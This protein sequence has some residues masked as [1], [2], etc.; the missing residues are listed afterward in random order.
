MGQVKLVLEPTRRLRSA[1]IVSTS[2]GD[3]SQIALQCLPVESGDPA[4]W[5]ILPAGE[6]LVPTLSELVAPAEAPPENSPARLLLQDES[7]APFSLSEDFLMQRGPGRRAPTAILLIV[8]D[9]HAIRGGSGSELQAAAQ[10]V[11]DVQR[12]RLRAAAVA[13]GRVEVRPLPAWRGLA[14]FNVKEFSRADLR[15]AADAFRALW[16]GRVDAV[17]GEE[18]ARPLVWTLGDGELLRSLCAGEERAVIVIGPELQ[19]VR[20]IPLRAGQKAGDL[21]SRIEEAIREIEIE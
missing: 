20:T 15:K 14:I 1:E 16:S 10:A 11:Q 7:L 21:A 5:E 2:A 19:L 3:S 6:R 18:P 9:A 13:S 17:P 12:R 4:S 8:F